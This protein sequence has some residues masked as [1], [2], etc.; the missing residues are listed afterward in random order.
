MSLQVFTPVVIE[1]LGDVLDKH[2][3]PK[4]QGG[5]MMFAMAMMAHGGVRKRKS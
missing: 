1:A 2:G 5:V 4:D 3:F